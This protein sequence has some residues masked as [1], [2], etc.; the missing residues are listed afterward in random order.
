MGMTWWCTSVMGDWGRRAAS[1]RP[2]WSI[3]ETLSQKNNPL[4]KTKQSDHAMFWQGCVTN[5][6]LINSCTGVWIQGFTL[7]RQ[8]LYHLSP[9]ISHFCDFFFPHIGSYKPSAWAGF[10]LWSFEL[11]SA[12]WVARITGMSHLSPCWDLEC[13]PK[14]HEVKT[15]SSAQCYGNAV[16]PV[17]GGALYEVFSSLEPGACRE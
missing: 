2:V 14:A 17:R 9:S 1:S 15:F 3:L 11:I 5:G 6:T 10:E 4:K 8:A 13:N 12:S 7:A 16:E